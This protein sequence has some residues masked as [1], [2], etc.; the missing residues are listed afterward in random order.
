MVIIQLYALCSAH[1]KCSYHLSANNAIT[2]PPT[3]LPMLY[4]FVPVTYSFHNWKPVPPIPLNPF[5][6]PLHP[7]PSSNYQF[8]LH[9][10]G[11]ASFCFYMF[12][13]FHTE[14]KSCGIHFSVILL[15][16]PI[17][18]HPMRN[19]PRQQCL[20]NMASSKKN[21]VRVGKKV[22]LLQLLVK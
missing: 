20:F 7:L 4:L 11:S 17:C 12:S 14:V 9:I 16:S 6:R 22:W 8:V 19:V 5:Y 10:Y 21:C 1:H 2:V 3:I 13:R 18:C 15:I